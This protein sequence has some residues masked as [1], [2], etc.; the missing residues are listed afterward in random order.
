MRIKEEHKEL[1]AFTFP[2]G[3]YEFN[4]LQLGLSNTPA[5][6]QRLMNTV[7]R[8]LIGIEWGVFVDYVNCFSCSAEEHAIELESVL[9]SC[10]LGNVCLPS[11]RCNTWAIFCLKVEFHPPPKKVK[12]ENQY[13]TPKND[14]DVRAFL[15]L[16]SFYRRLLS[17]FAQI[18]RFLTVLTGKD[19]EFIVVK[20]SKKLLRL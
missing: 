4:R 18:A 11:L 10:T 2:S 16:A 8:N 3:H 13:P 9:H 17:D 12:A 6:F 5:D 15:G 1:T 19:K 20:N 7:L 14:K